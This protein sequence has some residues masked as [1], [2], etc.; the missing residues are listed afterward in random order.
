MYK[1]S[2]DC[3]IVGSGLGGLSAAAY[4]ATHG[5]SVC[6]LEQAKNFGGYG[7][8]FV[9]DGFA[10]DCAIHSVFSWKFVRSCL[11]EL[12]GNTSLGVVPARR[13][14]HIIFEDGDYWATTFPYMTKTLQEKFPEEKEAIEKYFGDLVKSMT[15]LL[16]ISSKTDASKEEILNAVRKYPYLWLNS[17]EDVMD[18][19]FT[20]SDVKAYILGTHDAYLYDYAWNYSAYHLFH[21]KQINQGHAIKGGSR[22][23]VDE[24]VRII[25]INGGELYNSSLVTKIGVENNK[26]TGV[27]LDDG[28]EI[29]ANT[30]VISNADAKLTIEKMIGIENVPKTMLDEF[31]LWDKSGYSLSYYIVNLGL[32]IDLHEKYGMEHD[33]TIYFP[34]KDIPRVHKDINNNILPEDF[35]L[36][37]VFPSVNDPTVAP[38]GC[39]TA[40]ISMLVPYTM[41]NET[42]CEKD[43]FDG[44]RQVKDKGEKYYAKKEEVA[45]EMIAMAERV[46]PELS[47]HI[48][49][50]EVWTPQSFQDATLNHHGATIGFIKLPPTSE[51]KHQMDKLGMPACTDIDSLYMVGHWTEFGLSAGSVINSGRSVAYKILGIP[52]PPKCTSDKNDRVK[53]FSK[54]ILV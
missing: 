1:K 15:A 46:L 5:K 12:G 18:H 14:D 36:W 7:Q 31:K 24:F 29:K 52:L 44:F 22:N 20:S 19:Y 2:Y 34:S 47:E 54:E 41:L 16:E 53:N 48:V 21:I 33:L 27:V 51:T 37:M 50:K 43:Y 40:I 8:T 39:S 23:L 28:T 9:K 10:F 45:N 30:A 42:E 25:K 17:L 38:P 6:V 4:L 49:V 3:V 11:K 26:A 35:W 13:G 32:D